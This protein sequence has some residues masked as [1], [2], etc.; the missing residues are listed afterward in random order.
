M[1]LKPQQLCELMASCEL[2]ESD[3]QAL[4]ALGARVRSDGLGSSSHP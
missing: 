1:Q 2:V 4:Q 3:P